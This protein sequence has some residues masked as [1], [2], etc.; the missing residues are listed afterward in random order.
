[1]VE[2]GRALA[3][4]LAIVLVLGLAAPAAAQEAPCDPFTE[5]AFRGEVPT[6]RE[7][8]GI[9]LG[10]RD[11]TTEESD[12]Y[13]QRVAVA[14]RRVV[15]GTLGRS[16]EGRPLRYAVVGHPTNVRPS[17]LQ[18]VRSASRTLM[19]PSTTADEAAAIARRFPAILWI[20]ANVHG[21]EESGTDASLR[22]LHEL[23]DRTDCAARRIV[24]H[25]V[26]VILPVQNPDGREADTRRNA[27]GFDLNRDWF[28]RTQPETD[29]KVEMLR[30]WPSPL[31]VD[32]H[33]MGAPDYFFPP[34]ADPIYHEVPDRS[35]AWING[36]YGP[37]MQQE[38]RERGIPFFN[39]ERYDLFYQGYGDTVPSTAF[40]AAGMTF[41]KNNAD[42][43]SERVLEQYIAQWTT[44]SAAVRDK[45]GLLRDW[46]AAWVEARRQGEAGELEPNEVVQ[47]ENEVQRPVPDVRVRHYFLRA[48]DRRRGR[49]LAELVRRLQR[50][51]VEVRRLTAP[52]AVP[53]FKPYHR[54]RA[55]V[56]LPAGTYWVPLAQA[57]KH[58][59]QAMLNE[60][61]YTPF[62]YFYDVTAWSQ[63]LLFNVP[64]GYSGAEL[65]PQAERVPV[66][67]APE[68]P[69]PP[70]RAP[71]IAVHQISA[72]SGTSIESAGWT[73]YLLDRWKLPHRDVT[74]AEMAAGALRDVDVLVIP[75]GSPKEGAEALGEAGTAAL[76]E[77][78]QAGGR[79]VAWSGGGALAAAAGVSSAQFADAAAVGLVV[80]GTLFRVAVDEGSPVGRHAGPFAWAM[81]LGEYVMR[82]P[83]AAKAP[84]VYPP[85]GSEDF[86]RSGFAEGEEALA[87]TAAV[88]DEAVGE[89]RA[90][91]FGFDPNFRAFTDGTQVL[92]RNA[93]LGPDPA[94]AAAARAG[95]RS[96]V[97][98]R[99]RAAAARARA[100][101]A[102]RRLPPLDAPL[103][104]TV[105]PASRGAAGRVLARFGA[106]AQVTRG[107][108]RVTF[109]IANPKGLAADEHPWARRL[110]GALER[111]GVSVVAYR[112]P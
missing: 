20:A 56:T 36:L 38:F 41:E 18:R 101:A 15:A 78:V 69:A 43:T 42:P 83:D 110:P 7:V 75:N 67:A 47:P 48:D 12:R 11:V 76:R 89:G 35:V 1:M 37:A 49:E 70:A 9:D 21:G 88:S 103:R 95:A 96:A 73:R 17:A 80:P 107:G 57:K 2:L 27:Y 28:A 100:A 3:L 112:A 71:R 5:P 87:G 4:A 46:H 29:A 111:A 50:M 106:R 13:L 22:V 16:V 34:N 91:V 104:L 61:T 51:D 93:L 19:D 44:L 81:H 60:D 55:E 10:E 30:R 14:S 45:A 77:W 63:P 39:Y 64:G 82:Q 54:P 65:A 40:I 31:F 52:L 109:L 97:A 99:A 108:G 32:A 85:A 66:L 53:D 68:A 94:R 8:L 24:R 62:P 90:V 84:V 92:L 59:A 74:A 79:L 105:A 58:W 72:T 25:A 26:V 98:A 33:E 102:A 86:A 6:P 23:A